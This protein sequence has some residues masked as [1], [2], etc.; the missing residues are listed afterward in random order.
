[1]SELN[2]LGAKQ[3]ANLVAT[4]KASAEEVVAACIARIEAREADVGAFQYF[5]ADYALKQAR[6]LD[7]GP[8][9]GVLHGVPLGVKDIIDTRDMPTGNGSRVY[10]DRHPISDASCVA[11]SRAAGAVILGKTVTTEFAYF[12]PGKTK[13]PHNLGHTTGGSSMGSA[14]GT[15]DHMFPIG[16][17]SQTAA[18]VTRPAAYC[19]TI[20]YKATTGDFDLQGVCGLAASFDTLGFLCR[21]LEDISLMREAL[22]GDA[23]KAPRADNAAPKVGFVRT[24]W[25]DQADAATH[26]ALESAAEKLAAEGAEVSELELPSGFEDL[27]ETHKLVMA[28]DAARARAYE[29]I[30][31]P[32]KLSPQFTA[33]MEDGNGVSYADYREAQAR[34]VGCRQK[35]ADLMASYDVLLAPSAPGEAPPGHDATGDPLFSRMWTLLYVPSVTLPVATGD[36]GLPIGVQVVGKAHGDGALISDAQWIHDRLK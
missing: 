33:L 30:Y 24:P 22:I 8:S 21:E 3:V 13:N 6:D 20:G 26:R 18:S 15:A 12:F 17:G 27:V 10:P 31:H 28:F 16:F 5:D 9:K 14:A 19:G 34:S 11:L 1:M 7:N 2:E 23:P 36:T 32:D 4:K 29:Y 35:L 25:W